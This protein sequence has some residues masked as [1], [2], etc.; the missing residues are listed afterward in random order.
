M[1][2]VFSRPTSVR[3]LWTGLRLHKPTM[4]TSKLCFGSQGEHWF[5][6]TFV[7]QV[8]S[9]VESCN[10]I[11]PCR[12]NH[13][14]VGELWMWGHWVDPFWACNFSFPN[15]MIFSREFSFCVLIIYTY[16]CSCTWLN[17]EGGGLHSETKCLLIPMRPE[18][19]STA[20]TGLKFLYI[21]SGY[22][23]QCN[24]ILLRLTMI[25]WS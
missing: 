6:F 24:V 19:I 10:S 9:T 16:K 12:T 4:A 3:H 17:F 11:G 1:L 15:T 20:C 21:R 22:F 23:L 2:A 14:A 13:L 25:K 8:T 5:S 18:N 7:S